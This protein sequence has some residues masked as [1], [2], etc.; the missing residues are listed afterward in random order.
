MAKSAKPSWQVQR[1]RKARERSG[2]PAGARHEVMSLHI[3]ETQS[4]LKDA[5]HPDLVA[6]LV[7]SHH[8][9]C[10]PLAPAVP[11]ARPVSVPTAIGSAGSE[12]SSDSGLA[13]F[14]SG[15]VERFARLSDTYG[16]H[17]LAWLEALLRL[18]DWKRS[19]L[20]A[21]TWQR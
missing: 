20:E 5:A 4:L 19:E 21:T 9:H 7:A 17:G 12:V 18:A 15:L 1:N 14:N 3:A 16:P 13:A 2:Y 8:G 11:D 10:R 6:H